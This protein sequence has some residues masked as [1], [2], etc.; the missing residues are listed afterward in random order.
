MSVLRKTFAACVALLLAVGAGAQ[1]TPHFPIERYTL[2]N[3]LRVVFVEDHSLPLVA[4][5]V[6]YNVGSRN[7]I[8]GKTGFAHL[9]EH[10]MFQGSEHMKKGEFFK[11]IADAGGDVNGRTMDECTIYHEVVPTEKL[12]TLLWAEADRM[13]SLAVNEDNL[14]NQKD[15]VKEEKRMNFDNNPYSDAQQKVTELAY[16][17]FSNQHSTI[18]SM[19]DLDAAPLEY[20]QYF[21]K[22]Y[23]VPNNA[24][25]V[26]T[27]DFEPKVTKPLIQ[28]FFGTIP[29]KP[30][31]PKTDI[32]ETKQTKMRKLVLDVPNAPAP[33]MFMTWPIPSVDSPELPAI[34][35]LNELLFSG[36]E[37][38]AS[39]DIGAGEHFAGFGGYVDAQRGPTLLE[40]QTQYRPDVDPDKLID[41]M[42]VQIQRVQNEAP[43]KEELDRTKA[44]LLAQEYRRNM[45]P[46]LE[47]VLVITRQTLANDRPEDTFKIYEKILAVT[48]EQV[49]AVAKKY[50]LRDTMSLVIVKTKEEAKK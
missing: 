32:T 1:K 18:G 19:A 48:P 5:A 29:R 25:L 20:V 8:K 14:K 15:V 38:R 6:G 9:F 11:K 10:M 44:N 30:D 43:A 2:D 27:G 46:L 40:I 12:P 16:T 24:V 4:I 50:L 41:Q 28:K 17:N 22:T 37:N 21:F 36:K 39:S 49:Q 23:Y 3:G 45:E 33:I 34:I 47:R 13:R 35:L 7:E 26:V 31:P 42:Y